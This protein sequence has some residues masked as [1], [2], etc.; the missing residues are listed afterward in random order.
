MQLIL[1]K[2]IE[3]NI[4]YYHSNIKNRKYIL[5]RLKFTKISDRI[6]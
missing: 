5:K 4:V 1:S 3:I 2:I 6:D